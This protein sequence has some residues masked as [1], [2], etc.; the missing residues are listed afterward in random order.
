V[1]CKQPVKK[2]IEDILIRMTL[3]EKV[4]QMCSV[5][6]EEDCNI[7]RHKDKIVSLFKAKKFIAKGIGT[8]CCPV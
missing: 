6:V 3:D 2:K 1:N 4:Y 7:P 5:Y 8:I